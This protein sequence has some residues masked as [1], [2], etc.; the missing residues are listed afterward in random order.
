MADYCERIIKSRKAGYD[1]WQRNT[2]RQLL[3][4]VRWNVD[5]LEPCETDCSALM[6]VCAEAAGVDMSKAYQAGNAPATF[7]M[8]TQYAKTGAFDLL[9]DNKYLSS[10]KYLCRGDI[11]VNEQHH[12]CMVL[13]DGARGGDEREMVEKSKIIVDG[14][15]VPVERILKNNTNYIKIRDLAEALG[16]KVGFQGSI[17]TL[18]SKK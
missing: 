17:A 7:Q 4:S 16:L 3:K 2:L 14:K 1:Q 11:L 8:R 18:D 12:T 9:T 6:A 5:K 13:S 15:E 10:D